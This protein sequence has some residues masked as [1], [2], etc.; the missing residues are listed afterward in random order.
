MRYASCYPGPSICQVPSDNVNRRAELH[1]APS[2]DIL[3]LGVRVTLST[4][5]ISPT[6]V[7]DKIMVNNEVY[8]GNKYS[9]STEIAASKMFQGRKVKIQFELYREFDGGVEICSVVELEIV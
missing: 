6:V 8:R 5:G 7:Y 3:S 4:R 1:F 2:Q 9:M